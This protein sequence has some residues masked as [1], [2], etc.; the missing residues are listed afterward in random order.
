MHAG[1]PGPGLWCLGASQLACSCPHTP[2][3]PALCTHLQQQREAL[4]DKF[5]ELRQK[6]EALE[7]LVTDAEPRT[8][9]AASCS[10]G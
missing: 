10:P 9:C 3:C 6:S 4:K 2:P 8:R 7:Q 5:G 1:D